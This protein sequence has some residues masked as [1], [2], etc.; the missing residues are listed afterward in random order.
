MQTFTMTAGLKLRGSR[1]LPNVSSIIKH[2]EVLGGLN[3]KY[4]FLKV[5]LI[6][7]AVL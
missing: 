3:A 5:L 2:C 7:A 6:E 4:L 1:A